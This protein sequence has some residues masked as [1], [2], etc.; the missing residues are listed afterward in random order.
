M[1]EKLFPRNNKNW[2]IFYKKFFEEDAVK[3]PNDFVKFPA[4][5]YWVHTV[6]TTKKPR[7][8]LPR[9]NSQS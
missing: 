8:D 2:M 1:A 7:F 3:D 9:S 5:E 6:I 4:V